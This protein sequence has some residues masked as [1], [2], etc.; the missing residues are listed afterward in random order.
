MKRIFLVA[1]LLFATILCFSQQKTAR[2][3]LKNGTVIS[4][5]LVELDPLSHI[6]VNIAGLETRIEMQNVASVESSE[7]VD[8]SK[9]SVIIEPVIE[10]LNVPDSFTIPFEKSPIEM[11]LV[12]G[13][14]FMMGFDGWRSISFNSEPVH[15]VRLNSF[16]VSKEPITID[17]AREI[18]NKKYFNTRVP[19]GHYAPIDW[20]TANELVSKLSKKSSLPLRIISEAQWEYIAT[21]GWDQAIKTIKDEFEWCYDYYADYPETQEAL[22]NPLGP[23]KGVVHV[24]RV[25]S[26]DKDEHH[27]R[28]VARPGNSIPTAIRIV[29]SAED[30]KGR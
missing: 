7:L 5:M 24:V 13:G 21:T 14:G 17:Q 23:E 6:V 3:T 11:V 12:K 10:S 1:T 30:Y 15:P 4:G 9:K 18:L 29:M 19:Y 26:D 8:P 20:D 22:L 27:K 28:L 2:V 16:Y 25:W